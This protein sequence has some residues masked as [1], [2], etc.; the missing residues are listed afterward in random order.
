MKTDRHLE[1]QKQDKHQD[2]VLRVSDGTSAHEAISCHNNVNSNWPH[3]K[4]SVSMKAIYSAT[5]KQ[6]MEAMNLKGVR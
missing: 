4:T 5:T 1:D 2:A 3:K 6:M